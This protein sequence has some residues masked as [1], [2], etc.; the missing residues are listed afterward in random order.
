MKIDVSRLEL[1]AALQFCAKAVSPR[2]PIPAMTMLL[3]RGSRNKLTIAGASHELFASK[4]VTCESDG[5]AE[6]I[7]IPVQQIVGLMNNLPDESVELDFD[8]DKLRVI[9]PFAKSTIRGIPAEDFPEFP[10]A[11]TKLMDISEDMLKMLGKWF[12]PFTLPEN[13]IAHPQFSGVRLLR[14]SGKFSIWSFADILASYW[15]EP[16]EGEDFDYAIFAP[17]LSLAKELD[18]VQL[19]TDEGNAH[20]ILKDESDTLLATSLLY[21]N[22]ISV[23]EHCAKREGDITFSASSS[24]LLRSVKLA[25]T[26][27]GGDKFRTVILDVQEGK[28]ILSAKSDKNDD[29]EREQVAVTVGTGRVKLDANKLMNILNAIDG[30]AEFSIVPAGLE[31]FIGV[32]IRQAGEA[33]FTH[34]I[35]PMN[36][37]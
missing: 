24:E 7:C 8:S 10:V 2:S 30:D 18:G 26:T 19:W 12:V 28:V 35:M 29:F 31:R 13:E 1:L 33:R 22:W 27:F 25:N 16:Q 11:S 37:T 34:V 36:L 9:S 21:G 4:S 20:A 23:S 6:S 3:L 5:K 17:V 14:G 32:Q 15:E